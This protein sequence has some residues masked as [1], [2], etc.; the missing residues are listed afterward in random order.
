MFYTKGCCPSVSRKFR[1]EHLFFH[2]LIMPNHD[3]RHALLAL[4]TITAF[5]AVACA[6]IVRCKSQPALSTFTAFTLLLCQPLFILSMKFVKRPRRYWAAFH[7]TEMVWE[8]VV[9]DT[10]GRLIKAQGFADKSDEIYMGQGG[11]PPA[12]ALHVC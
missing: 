6:V 4:V 8:R 9:T 11:Y 12:P 7:D 1:A 5:V 3:H 10:A 2:A